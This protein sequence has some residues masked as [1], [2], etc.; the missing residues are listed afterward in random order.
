MT[1]PST[2]PARNKRAQQRRGKALPPIVPPGANAGCKAEH[3]RRP[4]PHTCPR[5]RPHNSRQN[6]HERLLHTSR[7]RTG[8][9]TG[10]VTSVSTGE[11]TGHGCSGRGLELASATDTSTSG[12]PTQL[13]KYTLPRPTP[14]AGA[15]TTIGLTVARDTGGGPLTISGARTNNSMGKDGK[16][17]G[18]DSVNEGDTCAGG[19]V[20]DHNK[21]EHETRSHNGLTSDRYTCRAHLLGKKST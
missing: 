15:R 19:G 5:T 14:T 16:R 21:P 13:Y 11:V 12:G 9:S 17:R 4:V 2:P 1:T 18:E 3:P 7:H 10:A 8:V 20:G 6:H